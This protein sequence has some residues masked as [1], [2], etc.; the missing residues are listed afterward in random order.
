MQLKEKN[1]FFQL[2]EADY[3]FTST[4]SKPISQFYS[5]LPFSALTLA[6]WL[7]FKTEGGKG[8]RRSTAVAESC[9]KDK[10]IEYLQIS[11]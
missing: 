6:F 2:P 1:S 5:Y 9:D 10:Y 7:H 4:N 11:R 8:R 3:T